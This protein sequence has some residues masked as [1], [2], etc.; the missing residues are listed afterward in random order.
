M[1]NEKKALKSEILALVEKYNQILESEDSEEK[2]VTVRVGFVE[3]D[4]N[5]YFYGEDSDYEGPCRTW[6]ELYTMQD[7]VGLEWRYRVE[8]PG[9]KRDVGWGWIASSRNC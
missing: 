1:S 9:V 4:C 6:S 5:T 2:P 8:A 3:L 7:E